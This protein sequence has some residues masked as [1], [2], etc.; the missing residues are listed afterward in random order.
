MLVVTLTMFAM[1]TTLWASELAILIQR[2]RLGLVTHPDLSV[3]DNVTDAAIAS[4]VEIWL[5]EVFFSF[6]VHLATYL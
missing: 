2:V 1:S 4:R 3:P 6:E 5:P